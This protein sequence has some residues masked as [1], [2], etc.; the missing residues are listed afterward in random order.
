[1]FANGEAKQVKKALTSQSH[2]F[3]SPR[4]NQRIGLHVWP[5]VLHPPFADRQFVL[6][7]LMQTR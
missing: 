5:S 2:Q 1:M 3:V 4:G 7:S 6:R